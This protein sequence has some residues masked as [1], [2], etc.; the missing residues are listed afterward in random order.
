MSNMQDNIARIRIIS[1]SERPADVPFNWIIMNA[2]RPL[3]G[4]KTNL[5]DNPEGLFT[6][7]IDPAESDAPRMIKENRTLNACTVVYL[8][9][10]LLL[11]I[12]LAHYAAKAYTKEQIDRI[13]RCA[14]KAPDLSSPANSVISTHGWDVLNGAFNPTRN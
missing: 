2:P 6:V 13:A 7:A 3:D 14:A 8:T 5:P 12:G 1:S 9:P 11:Q 4:H 10:D